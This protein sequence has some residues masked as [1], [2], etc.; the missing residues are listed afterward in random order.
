MI[1]S[2]TTSVMPRHSFGRNQT[3]EGRLIRTGSLETTT[4]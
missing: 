4:R 3:G 2:I 1:A